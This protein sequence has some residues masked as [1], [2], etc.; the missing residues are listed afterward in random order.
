MISFFNERAR[1]RERSLPYR[2]WAQ[3]IDEIRCECCELQINDR[4]TKMKA[5]QQLQQLEMRRRRRQQQQ[6]QQHLSRMQHHRPHRRV[7]GRSGSSSSRSQTFVLQS[8]A[9][10]VCAYPLPLPTS[11]AHPCSKQACTNVAI[12]VFV[13][14]NTL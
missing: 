3:N 2:N 7:E 5:R 6:Q 4:N 9:D 13:S 14:S 10:F 8:V 12:I 1:E 11:P